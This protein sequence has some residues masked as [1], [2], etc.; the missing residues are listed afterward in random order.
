MTNQ[1][2]IIFTVIYN[3]HSNQHPNCCGLHLRYYNKLYVDYKW[4]Q[5]PC[6]YCC[7]DCVICG[8]H[9]SH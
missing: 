1:Y 2:I 6:K 3:A 4:I 5:N 8:T 9:R 7:S